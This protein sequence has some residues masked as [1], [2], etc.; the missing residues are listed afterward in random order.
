[1]GGKPRVKSKKLLESN[2]L[3]GEKRTRGQTEVKK[4]EGKTR[5]K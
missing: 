1:L 3:K 5:I 4:E 2:R